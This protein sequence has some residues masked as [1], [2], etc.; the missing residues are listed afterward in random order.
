MPSALEWEDWCL[1]TFFLNAAIDGRIDAIEIDDGKIIE[2]SGARDLDGARRQFLTAL[3]ALLD[4][5]LKGEVSPSFRTVGKAASRSLGE[6]E[7]RPNFVRIL[8]FFLW[9]QITVSKDEDEGDIRRMAT[10]ALGR[11]S[12]QVLVGLHNM[13]LALARWLRKHR[14]IVL[15][16]PDHGNETHVGITKRLAFPTK[17]DLDLLRRVRDEGNSRADLR[18]IVRRI[19]GDNFFDRTSP[20]FR[21]AFEYWRSTANVDED[22]AR[23]LPFMG[24]WTRV[25]AEKD[26]GTSIVLSC[27]E[28]GEIEAQKVLADGRARTLQSDGEFIKECRKLGGGIAKATKVGMLTLQRSGLA[29][30]TV[31]EGKRTDEYLISR[32]ALRKLPAL[33]QNKIKTRGEVRYLSWILCN[34]GAPK[35]AGSPT[36][37]SRSLRF[38]DKI[39]VGARGTYL[40]R[41]PMTPNV[42]YP[43]AQ[44]PVLVIEGQSYESTPI[45]DGIASFPQGVWNGPVRAQVGSQ[46][47]SLTLRGN[48]YPHADEDIRFIDRSRHVP[49]DGILQDTQPEDPESM[50]IGSFKPGV[51][52]D[53][54]LIA[55]QEALYARSART[56]TLQAAVEMAARVA[57]TGDAPD[58]WALVR[59]FIDSGWFDVPYVSQVPARTLVQRRPSYRLRRKGDLEGVSIEGPMPVLLEEAILRKAEGIGL[60]FERI[61]GRSAWSLPKI[62]VGSN[63]RDAL[64]E[65]IRSSDL[66]EL[67]V[68]TIR[69]KADEWAD[70]PVGEEFERTGTWN[71]AKVRFGGCYEDELWPRFVRMDRPTR[72]TNARYV[73]EHE[74]GCRE[75]FGSAN[76]ALLRYLD[77]QRTVA[78]EASGDAIR[79]THP[80]YRLP[81]AWARWL[82]TVHLRNCALEVGDAG[83]AC[84]YPASHSSAL[85]LSEI[86]PAVRAAIGLKTTESSLP[87]WMERTRVRLA[88]DHRPIWHDGRLR[89]EHDLTGLRTC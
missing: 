56:M 76:L 72:D 36:P 33:D 29:S 88:R 67:R 14:D 53:P 60:A 28:F 32:A 66:C 48:A 17:K 75:T 64:N 59:L 23:E 83:W 8:I 71:S 4:D 51:E 13:W 69:K 73:I 82:G 44:N 20:A 9:L 70:I 45:G 78:F 46:T 52:P 27:D 87:Q 38:A 21:R 22:A 16:L 55:L 31:S 77:L 7:A 40:G 18:S 41:W 12:P 1:E 6:S 81:S 68:A 49:D 84:V 43:G 15:Q 63:D 19:A 62:W 5:Y 80:R 61:L 79:S 65:F 39:R 26:I 3:P 50:Q 11:H 42:V 30:W 74:S 57:M 24:A 85:I 2:F 58:V 37:Q 34:I 25:L 86:Y 10:A 89:A 47:T 35:N 54:R